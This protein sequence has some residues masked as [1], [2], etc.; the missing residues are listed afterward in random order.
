MPFRREI[1]SLF[2][3]LEPTPL[4]ISESI[5]MMR[6][7]EHGVRVHM[8]PTSFDTLAVDTP[9]DLARVEALM[10]EDPLIKSY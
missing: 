3:T 9:E 4:E 2:A 5:D 7:I 8:V 6:F 1:L 10:R